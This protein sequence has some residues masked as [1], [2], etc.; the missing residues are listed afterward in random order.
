ML[1]THSLLQSEKEKKGDNVCIRAIYIYIY[2]VNSNTISH[3]TRSSKDGVT[4]EEVTY[5]LHMSL[6]R[7]DTSF[8]K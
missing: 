7:N 6:N 5:E 8:L 4:F 2:T 3:G 1:R